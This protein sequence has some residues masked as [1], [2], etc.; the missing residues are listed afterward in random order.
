MDLRHGKAAATSFHTDAMLNGQRPRQK[1]GTVFMAASGLVWQMSFPPSTGNHFKELRDSEDSTFFFF[2]RKKTEIED[3]ENKKTGKKNTVNF[4]AG[5]FNVF[6][7][8]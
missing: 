3:S 5:L 2:N 8:F 4:F 6:L 1:T 7:S